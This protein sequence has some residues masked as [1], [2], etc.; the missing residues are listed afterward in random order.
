MVAGDLRLTWIRRA[1]LGG[2]VWDGEAPL[3]EGVERYRIRVVDGGVLLREVEVTG[4][5]FTYAAAMRTADT[6][7][8]AAVVEV[9]QADALYGWGAPATRSL[10]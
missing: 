4:P 7:S 5:A 6:P 1:R 10:W 3:A 8:S 2:D 9:A